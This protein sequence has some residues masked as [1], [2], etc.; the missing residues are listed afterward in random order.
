VITR[1]RALDERSGGRRVACGPVWRA[2]RE[3]FAAWLEAEVPGVDIARDPAGN[4]WA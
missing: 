3:R 2:E 1:L 4:L